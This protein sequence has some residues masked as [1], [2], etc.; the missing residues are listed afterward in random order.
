MD[1]WIVGKTR[2]LPRTNKSRQSPLLTTS[3]RVAL[4]IEVFAHSIRQ[5]GSF[6][7]RAAGT[8]KVGIPSV[9]AKE[10]DKGHEEQ[11]NENPQNDHRD[12]A[13]APARRSD[14]A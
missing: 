13:R 10:E 14:G 4:T 6:Q 5:P 1:E 2:M 9:M 7:S 3:K 11:Q 12:R 8:W